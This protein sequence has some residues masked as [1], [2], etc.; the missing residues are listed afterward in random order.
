MDLKSYL[1]KRGIEFTEAAD[2]KLTVGGYLD[3]EG[4]GVTALPNGLTV[5]GSL[6]LRGTGVTALPNGLTVG[7]SLDLRGTGVTVLPENFTA[8]SVFLDP[9]KVSNVAYREKC[10]RQNRT[11]FA[12]WVGDVPFVAAGCFWGPL[13]KFES[14]VDENYNGAAAEK[15]KQAAR[16]CVAELAERLN[17]PFPNV[18]EAA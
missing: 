14:A 12:A 7:F 9:E 8:E 1:A 10:G 15:Y 3:L 4:T 16:D 5:G 13:D 11:I 2:G 6:Y 17:Q 18:T